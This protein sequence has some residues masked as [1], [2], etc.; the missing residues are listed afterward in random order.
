MFT[1]FEDYV[2]ICLTLL[3]YFLESACPLLNLH[4][5]DALKSLSKH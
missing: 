3:M 5:L 4:E 2:E 1:L